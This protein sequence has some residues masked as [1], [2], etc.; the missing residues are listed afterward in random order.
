MLT[1]G[2]TAMPV[3]VAAVTVSFGVPDFPFRDALSDTAPG[4]MAVTKPPDGLTLATAALA[5]V[6][7]TCDVTSW[8]L[9]SV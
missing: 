7:D 1:L 5:E 8:W 6:Q 3:A 4:A 9:L 2:V